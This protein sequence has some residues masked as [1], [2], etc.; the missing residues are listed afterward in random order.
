MSVSKRG[1]ASLSD[2]RRKEIAASG[3]R[4]AHKKGVAHKW[5]SEEAI[6]AGKKGKRKSAN[7]G[8]TTNNL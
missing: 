4:A 8:T 6:L 2:E 1:F 5:T 7:Y 3:G